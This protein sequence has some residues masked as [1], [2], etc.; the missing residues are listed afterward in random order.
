[1]K[2]SLLEDNTVTADYD[3]GKYENINSSHSDNALSPLSK[4]I[5]DAFPYRGAFTRSDGETVCDRIV[6]NGLTIKMTLYDMNGLEKVNKETN[7]FDP[8]EDMTSASQRVQDFAALVFTDEVRSAFIE[9]LPKVPVMIETQQMI[10]VDKGTDGAVKKTIDIPKGE[11]IVSVKSGKATAKTI[12][13]KDI[14]IM[15][16]VNEDGSEHMIP[17]KKI[18]A[19]GN[20]ETQRFHKKTGDFY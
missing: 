7:T 11:K 9:T 17:A 15:L 16:V 13:S 19:E 1:M 18:D 6:F 12:Y 8:L 20:V 10:R 3:D 4:S 2:I 5:A 14:W